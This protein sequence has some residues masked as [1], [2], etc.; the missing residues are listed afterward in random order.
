MSIS[1]FD[2]CTKIISCLADNGQTTKLLTFQHAIEL[3]MVLPGKAAKE[4]RTQ[5]A[6]IIRRYMAGDQTLIQ[7]I[8]ANA[9]STAPI[10]EAARATLCEQGDIPGP[11][12]LLPGNEQDNAICQRMEFERVRIYGLHSV[13]SAMCILNSLNPMW[14]NDT[15]LVQHLEDQIRQI[16]MTHAGARP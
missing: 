2:L 11:T 13:I 15:V 9:E 6:N 12:V 4:A 8:N 7:E 5:F 3:V 16:M 14:R 1:K 10:A